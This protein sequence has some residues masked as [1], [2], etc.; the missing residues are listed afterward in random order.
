MTL[1]RR[2]AGI[3]GGLLLVGVLA[4]CDEDDCAGGSRPS[5]GADPRVAGVKRPEIGIERTATGV[6]RPCVGVDRTKVGNPIDPIGV[7]RPDIERPVKKSAGGGGDR[8]A[9]VDP[10][11]PG[12]EAPTD[13]T[14][15]AGSGE[16]ALSA[17]LDE[18]DVAD[19]DSVDAPSASLEPLGV[20]EPLPPAELDDP[21]ADA[22]AEDGAL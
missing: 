17:P 4:G 15:G 1:L 3:A 7:N 21:W 6:K 11:D 13:E 19:A 9:V 20:L 5:T 8:P 18:P 22:P 14:G 16:S 2:C 12:D 10:T